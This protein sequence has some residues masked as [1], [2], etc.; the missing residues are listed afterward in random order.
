MKSHS[1]NVAQYIGRQINSFDATLHL[2]KMVKK[3]PSCENET[4]QL[5]FKMLQKKEK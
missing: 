3:K 5:E 1:C 2:H 4:F